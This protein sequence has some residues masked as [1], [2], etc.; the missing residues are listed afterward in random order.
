MAMMDSCQCDVA[1]AAPVVLD[2][3]REAANRRLMDS[4]KSEADKVAAY[5]D[6]Y[7]MQRARQDAEADTPHGQYVAQLNDAWRA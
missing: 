3:E 5:R 2:A 6:H 7:D 4:A 1:K